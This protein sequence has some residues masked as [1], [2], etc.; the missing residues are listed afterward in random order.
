MVRNNKK[1]NVLFFRRSKGSIKFW[2]IDVQVTVVKTS[3]IA[4]YTHTTQIYRPKKSKKVGNIL[5]TIQT[6]AVEL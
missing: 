5:R 3:I 6:T 4:G 1:I 2:T